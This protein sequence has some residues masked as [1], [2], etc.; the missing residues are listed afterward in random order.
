MGMRGG[1]RWVDP[2]IQRKRG[3][4]KGPYL[5]EGRSSVGEIKHVQTKRWAVARTASEVKDVRKKQE[6]VD[7]ARHKKKKHAAFQ[8]V[9]VEGVEIT[10]GIH[11][12]RTLR[13]DVADHA[14]QAGTKNEAP[15]RSVTRGKKKGAKRSQAVRMGQKKKHSILY[16]FRINCC[17][18]GRV[19]EKMTLRQRVEQVLGGRKRARTLPGESEEQGA[20]KENILCAV[21]WFLCYPKA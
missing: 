12:R 4:G 5:W 1:S 3:K 6:K 18:G 16:S 20:R 19:N 14:L 9:V 21:L 8:A 2:Q 11:L 7:S 15:K 17:F 13:G 10:S